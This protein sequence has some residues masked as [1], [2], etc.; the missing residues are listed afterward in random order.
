M[1]QTAWVWAVALAAGSLSVV[2][3]RDWYWLS[4][5]L[6]LFT[7]GLALLYRHCLLLPLLLLAA[8]TGLLA[9]LLLVRPV[10]ELPTAAFAGMP[11]WLWV[12]IGHGGSLLALLGAAVLIPQTQGMER[13]PMLV[14]QVERVRG[15]LYGLAVLTAFTMLN[16]WIAI[17]FDKG[18]NS[19]IWLKVGES[20]A[21]DMT[22]S[23]AWA[24]FAILLL[25][26]GLR[27]RSLGARRAGVLL[28][29]LTLIKLF[30]HDLARVGSVYRI[31]V[32]LGVA[33]I[34][35]TASFLYQRAAQK[36]DP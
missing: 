17:G 23:I 33:V 27:F 8:V 36:V 5:A 16:L 13:F 22:Y 28:L 15:W 20:F 3:I 4:L 2:F 6:A 1:Q 25:G 26:I 30:V 31:I 12:L 32:F 11:G 18:L 21:A 7:L 10:L 14:E 35:L 29:L 19:A 34:A 9:G 24:L